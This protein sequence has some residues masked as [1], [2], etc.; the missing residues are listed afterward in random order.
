M[1]NDFWLALYTSLK[2]LICEHI[3]LSKR[4]EFSHT[5]RPPAPCHVSSVILRKRK[6]WRRWKH[7]STAINK[8]FYNRVSSLCSKI[9]KRNHA[10]VERRLLNIFQQSFFKNVS[11][12]LHP[13]VNCHV[14]LIDG[15]GKH[16]SPDNISNCFLRKFSKNFN[17]D[18]SNSVR[19]QQQPVNEERFILLDD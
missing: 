5:W 1:I 11:N 19:I 18:V 15:D 17:A 9:I 10:N 7:C 6:A 3:P 16:E 4:R 2:R 14:T 13:D 12:N 8:E